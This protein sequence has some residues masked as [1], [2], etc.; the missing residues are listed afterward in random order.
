MERKNHYYVLVCTDFGPVFVTN[1]LSG[2]RAE[3]DRLKAPM[4]CPKWQ[5]EEIAD[6]LSMNGYTAMMV[7]FRRECL[8]QPYY[9]ENGHWEWKLGSIKQKEEVKDEEPTCTA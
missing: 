8:N 6:G 2:H 9:Y 1:L 5:A 7:V 3:W 4:E